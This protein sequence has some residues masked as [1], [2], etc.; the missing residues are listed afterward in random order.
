MNYV[1]MLKKT[2][3]EAK[4]ATGMSADNIAA[5]LAAITDRLKGPLGNAE[6]IILCAERASLRKAQAAGGE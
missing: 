6:R 3:D 1:Q 4:P 2:M 5:A